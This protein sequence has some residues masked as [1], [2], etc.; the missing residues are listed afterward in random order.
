MRPFWGRVLGVFNRA[1][2]LIDETGRV[3]AVVLP[4]VGNGPFTIMIEGVPGMFE[5]LDSPQPVSATPQELIV[6]QWRIVLSQAEIWEPKID[7][8]SQPFNLDL[9]VDLLPHYADWPNFTEDTPWTKN[10]ALAGRQAAAQLMRAIIQADSDDRL[11]AAVGRLAGLG[12]GLTPAGDDYL[13]GA[14]AALWLSGQPDNLPGIAEVAGARTNAL[15]GSFLNAAARGEF[16]ESWHR[17]V[18]AWRHEDNQA[19]IEAIEWI[20]RF[21]AS[22]GLDALAGFTKTLLSLPRRSIPSPL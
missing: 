20:A 1:C 22:S 5:A 16:M 17:L 14:M 3:I 4:V 9:L 8:P 7:P 15:S 19:I 10:M 13:L 21:G 11:E 12:P 18:R 2:N 6:G